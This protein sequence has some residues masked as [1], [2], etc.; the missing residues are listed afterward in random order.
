MIQDDNVWSLESYQLVSSSEC[1]SY[2][3]CVCWGQDEDT[4]YAGG[5]AGAL[6][7]LQRGD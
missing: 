1:G 6:V 2:M 5:Q 4:I 3:N 7:K